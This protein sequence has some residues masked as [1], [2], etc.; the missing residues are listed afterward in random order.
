[1]GGRERESRVFP[2]QGKEE[3]ILSIALTQDFLVYATQV[4]IYIIY[5]LRLLPAYIY[6][7]TSL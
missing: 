6:D 1:M 4:H 5:N 2:E 3:Y 7:G